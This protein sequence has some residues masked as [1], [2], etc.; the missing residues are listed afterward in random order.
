MWHYPIYHN[1]LYAHLIAPFSSYALA[2]V[3]VIIVSYH[4]ISAPENFDCVLA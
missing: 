1:H 4:T 3:P 2:P